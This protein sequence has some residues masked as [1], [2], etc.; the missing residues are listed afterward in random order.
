MFFY[1][2]KLI[3]ISEQLNDYS[4]YIEIYTD[5]EAESEQTISSLPVLLMSCLLL[6]SSSCVGSPTALT[7]S[8]NAVSPTVLPAALHEESPRVLE[9][10]MVHCKAGSSA[11]SSC[12]ETSCYN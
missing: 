5:Q 12:E 8:E 6:Q 4:I 11:L 2:V 1:F 10:P 7:S 3:P 9:G